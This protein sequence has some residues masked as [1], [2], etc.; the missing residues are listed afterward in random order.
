MSG[1]RADLTADL[2]RVSG[3][4]EIWPVPAAGGDILTLF[5]DDG[6]GKASD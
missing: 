3:I 5:R 6:E 1:L 4:N 2:T